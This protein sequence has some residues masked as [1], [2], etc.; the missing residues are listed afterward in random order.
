MRNSIKLTRKLQKEREK[1]I[2]KMSR[3]DITEEEWE[4]YKKQFDTY[5]T[6]LKH[7]PWASGDA[8]LTVL[9]NLL[10]IGMILNFEQVNLLQTKA[11]AFVMKGK[12]K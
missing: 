8:V 3:D 5:T 1:L 6:A 7:H 11:L 9:G 12:V 4:F 10:G 2:E